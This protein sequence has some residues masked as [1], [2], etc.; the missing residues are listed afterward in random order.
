MRYAIS[1]WIYAGE[2][3]R[4]SFARLA[5]FGYQA[6]ELVGEPDRIAVPEAQA[7]SRE[8]A[9]P[10]TSVL[11][12]CIW[13]IPG[14]D[15]ASPDEKERAAAVE[16]G[17]ACVDLA[18]D[19]GAPV[20]VVL[21]SPAG[22]TAPTGHPKTE[23]EWNKGA[24]RE[25]DLA[26]GSL[27]QLADYAAR[28]KV[29]LGLEPVNRYES[30]LVTNLDQALRFLEAVGAENLKLH[31]DTFHMNIEEADP[32]Q[33]IRQAGELLVNIHLSDSNRLPPGQGHT[34]FLGLL[35]ALHQIDYLGALTLEPVPP[36]SDALMAAD[37]SALPLRDRYAEEGIRFLERLEQEL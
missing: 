31:L 20:L 21:P 10:V 33:A 28:R 4:D 1:N 3:L 17:Q 2:P 25:W 8:F 6:I 35:R 26:V 5:R 11:T 14:R 37:A 34:D 9:I 32:A 24:A 15:L 19:L 22:R 27:R 18:A 30:F 23:A 36:G 7:L 12:W 29:L 13:G 16:Y